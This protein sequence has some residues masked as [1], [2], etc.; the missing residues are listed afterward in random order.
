MIALLFFV[1]YLL[2]CLFSLP[3]LYPFFLA[4]SSYFVY[5]LSLFFVVFLCLSSSL[6]QTSSSFVT[7]FIK[8][9]T[10]L[11]PI[12]FTNVKYHNH[13]HNYL[14]RQQLQQEVNAAPL[15]GPLTLEGTAPRQGIQATN[16]LLTSGNP[17]VWPIHCCLTAPFRP[18]APQAYTASQHQPR[19][20]KALVSTA[21]GE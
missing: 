4:F 7:F 8:S 10:F 2:L 20:R 17:P 19:P 3:L 21:E 13:H 6:S 9:T 15:T 12:H 14:Q 16:A 1:L 11:S 18:A 5:F